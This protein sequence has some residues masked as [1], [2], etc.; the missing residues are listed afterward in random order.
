M[1]EELGPL[2]GGTK[3][4]IIILTG[5]SGSGK[6][7][8]L[9]ALEDSGFFCVDNLPPQ[10]I[11][12]FASIEASA[13]GTRKMA[14]G[15]D[16]REK[17]LLPVVESLLLPLRNKYNIEV[18]F[19]EAETDVLIRRFKETRRP[20][21]L[22]ASG[23]GIEEAIASEKRLLQPLRDSADRIIDT[24]AYTP[25]QLRAFMI[26]AFGSG[27]VSGGRMAVTLISFGYKFGIP[28]TA[29]LLFDA[30][31]LPNPYFVPELRE[32]TGAD[33]R[34]AEFVL[35]SAEADEFA[36]KISDLL[37]FLIP[38]YEKEGR[39]YLTV[40]VGCTGGRHR[41]PVIVE[42]LASLLKRIAPSVDV[43]HRDI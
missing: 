41:S 35:G 7:V 11:D 23:V 10:L 29:D 21:P 28:H 20:H 24:S 32:L 26:S 14:V 43:I 36:N 16:V 17:E 42:R 37:D 6:T 30:R 8:A 13:L 39:A 12:S 34:V 9:R 25:H 4:T 19:L 33:P 2:S 3:S 1:P 31:F 38:L 22:G 18:V 15:I 5:L 27:G 40:G